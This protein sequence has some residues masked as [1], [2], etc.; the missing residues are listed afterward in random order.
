MSTV[1]LWAVEAGRTQ[2]HEG[3]FGLRG[4]LGAQGVAGIVVSIVLEQWFSPCGP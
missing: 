4:T 2:I 1:G 3:Q